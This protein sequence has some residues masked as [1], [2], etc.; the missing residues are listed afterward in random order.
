MNDAVPRTG[1]QRPAGR[2]HRRIH[3]RVTTQGRGTQ[4]FLGGRLDLTVALG[5][6]R[7]DPLPVKEKTRA[8]QFGGAIG[9]Y[10]HRFLRSV[11]I[12]DT[13][14]SFGPAVTVAFRPPAL[15]QGLLTVAT[16]PG[17]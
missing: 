8:I 9:K 15:D 7:L 3:V 16:P 6:P 10:G 5:A 13:V 12:C 17:G 4:Q 14:A 11:G 2:R 1:I